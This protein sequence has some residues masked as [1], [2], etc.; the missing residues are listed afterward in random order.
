MNHSGDD[1]GPTLFPG[2]TAR[3][4]GTAF[5]NQLRAEEQMKKVWIRNN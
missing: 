3:Y 5:E 2:V 1:S 4:G